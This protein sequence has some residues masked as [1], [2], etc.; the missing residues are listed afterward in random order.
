MMDCVLRVVCIGWGEVCS[1]LRGPL[2]QVRR[3]GDADPGPRF[4]QDAPRKLR[5]GG[6]AAA[7][8]A[9]QGACLL[10]CMAA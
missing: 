10:C 7:G 1:Y 5:R 3:L 4:S 9:Q 2:G 8:G 6:G